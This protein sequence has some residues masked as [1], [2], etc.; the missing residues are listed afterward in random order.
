MEGT[1]ISLLP[2]LHTPLLSLL[3]ASPP[4]GTFVTVSDLH[5]HLIISQSLAYM[6]VTL[7]AVRAV[8]SVFCGFGQLHSDGIHH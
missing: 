1:K 6:S 7:R 8:R 3:S 5:G 4:G 2:L